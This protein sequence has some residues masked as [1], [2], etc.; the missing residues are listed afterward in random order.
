[1]KI[2]KGQ[3]K[4]K[5]KVPDNVTPFFFSIYTYNEILCFNTVFLK[6][7]SFRDKAKSKVAIVIIS[8]KSTC[9]LNCLKGTQ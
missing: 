3:A 1:M 6:P 4:D 7:V 2:V 8:N 5:V 9:W